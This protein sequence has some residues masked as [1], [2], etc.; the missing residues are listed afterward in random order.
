MCRKINIPYCIYLSHHNNVVSLFSFTEYEVIFLYFLWCAD[1]GYKCQQT[2]WLNLVSRNLNLM[3]R[4]SVRMCTYLEVMIGLMWPDF[5]LFADDFWCRHFFL[6]III[7]TTTPTIN[8]ARKPETTP[9]IIAIFDLSPSS[10]V[11]TFTSAAAPKI[12]WD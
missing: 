6:R 3:Y 2:S 4:A 11:S 8:M 10:S 1:A 7:A 5:K 9:A 12:L